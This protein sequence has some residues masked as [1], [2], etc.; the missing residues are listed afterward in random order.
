MMKT[1]NRKNYEAKYFEKKKLHSQTLTYLENHNYTLIIHY[2]LFS[3][4]MDINT[5]LQMLINTIRMKYNE[6]LR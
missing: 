1:H 3:V 4:P 2:L 6:I 5:N